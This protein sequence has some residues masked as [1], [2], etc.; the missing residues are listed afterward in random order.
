MRVLRPGSALAEVTPHPLF[1]D[2]VVLQ[3]GMAVP[4]WGTADDGER[5]TVKIQ[6]QEG[7]ATARDGKWMVRLKEL[8]AGGPYMLTITGKTTCVIGNVLVGEVWIC[9]GQSN[10][11]MNLS[12]CA[13]AERVMAASK[14]PML[15]LFTVPEGAPLRRGQGGWKEASPG[16]VG[17]F[18][19]V[20]Y[21]FGRDL[22][23]ALDVPVGLINSSD[24][25]TPAEAWI[26]REGLESEPSLKDILA[27]DAQLLTG[28]PA[29]LAR[30]PA[31]LE[32][33]KT[34][35]AE[36]KKSGKRARTGQGRLGRP[37]VLY[38]GMI[39]P[40]SRWR[41][42]ASSGIKARGTRVRAYQYQLLLTTLIKSWR[43]AWGQGSFPFLIVQLAP[44]QKI[45]TQPAESL[46]A[47]LPRARLKTSH[48]VPNTALAVI[49]DV[50]EEDDIHPRR[51]APV[52]ARLALAARALAY[53]ERIESSGPAFTRMDVAGSRAVLHFDHAG[54]GL[55]AKDGPLKGFTIAGADRMFGIAEA[56]IEGDTVVVHS[57]RV[58]HPLAVRY[59]WANYPLGNLWNKQDLPASPFRTDDFPMTTLP[60]PRAGAGRR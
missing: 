19:G 6:N 17:S 20:G 35:V 44:Y 13:D 52:G 15:R 5:V 14:D 4:D 37:S 48:A 26:R 10:M 34:A 11:A 3:R 7:Q 42:G 33:H 40:L 22:R 2:T 54:D 29:A 51:K 60:R 46:W 53:G 16:T 30:Y 55:V 25:G 59:G 38:N 18:S 58:E 50:G 28:Y 21:F 1:S 32:A 47:E 27:R 31:E 45:E 56:E 24:G 9:S 8:K 49:T 43:D 57:D 12:R 39:A 41:S 23:A 36:A